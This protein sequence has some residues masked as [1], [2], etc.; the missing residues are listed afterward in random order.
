MEA[1]KLKIEVDVFWLR[2]LQDAI[3]FLMSHLGSN[4]LDLRV[5]ISGSDWKGAMKLE[6]LYT[7]IGPLQTVEARDV[8]SLSVVCEVF[9]IEDGSPAVHIGQIR[10]EESATLARRKLQKLLPDLEKGMLNSWQD[11]GGDDGYMVRC[12]VSRN[13]IRM[14][15]PD[16]LEEATED[17]SHCNART[18][19]AIHHA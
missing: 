2:D 18:D 1:Q 3:S 4:N 17:L 11:G 6:E 12:I 15:Q 19:L 8:V 16:S 9:T 13:L 7:A 14:E 5:N 10:V